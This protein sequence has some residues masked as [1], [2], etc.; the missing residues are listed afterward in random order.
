MHDFNIDQFKYRIRL[1]V[2]L[3][4]VALFCFSAWSIISDRKAALVT[5]EHNVTGYARALAEHSES[6]FAESDRVLRDLLYD[7]KRES[8]ER[9]LGTQELFLELRRQ[10][11]D[12]PQIGA[13][14]LVDKNGTMYSN[15]NEFPP[16]PISVVDREYFQFYLHH[17]EAELT[18]SKPVMSRLVNRWRFN[19]MRPMSR[20]GEPFSGIAA[21]AFEVGYF[22]SFFTS[23]SLGPSGRI[24]LVRNDGAPLVCEP[25][26]KN[27]FDV[28]M[29]N[30]V[31]FRDKL[32][33]APS[34]SYRVDRGALDG[35]ARI[36]AYQRLKR[37]PVV[38]LVSVSEAE[39][40][41][42]WERRALQQLLLTVAISFILGYLTRLILRHL[43]RLKFTIALVEGQQEQLKV[44]AALMEAANDAIV[45]TETTGKLIQFNPALCQMTGFSNEELS[46]M[47]LQD[48]VT[49]ESA[50][51]FAFA[52]DLLKERDSISYESAFQTK[53]GGSVPV[54]VHSLNMT[55]DSRPLVLNIARDITQRKQSERREQDRLKILEELATG[56][57]L[58]D[59]LNAIVRFV[60]QQSP[61]ALCSV[62]LFD[63]DKGRLR[64]GAA[65]SLPDF[66][67]KAVD[68]ILI[69]MGVG[70]CGTAAFLKKRVVVEDVVGHPHW[71][72]FQP[73]LDAGLRACWSEPILASDGKLIGTFAIYNREPKAPGPEEIALIESAAH[74]ASL[75]IERSRGDENRKRL[76]E[77][78][79]HVQK[80]DAIGQLAAGVAHD[81]NNLLTPILVYA[82]LLRTTVTDEKQ[83]KKADG[84]ASAALKAKEL[85]QKLLSFGRKQMLH[86]EVLDLN[87][88]VRSFEEIITRTVRESIVVDLELSPEPLEVN[89]DRGQLEQ[90]LLNLVVNAQDAIRG[91]GTVTVRSERKELEKGFVRPRPGLKVGTYCHLSFSD[92]GCGMDE[93]TLQHIFEPFFTTKPVGEGTG[94][95]LATIYGIVKQH[96]G[97]IEVQSRVGEGSTFDIY[98]PAAAG[99][100]KP[101]PEPAP[102]RRREGAQGTVLV[103][104]DNEMIR[105]M[106]VELLASAGYQVLVAEQPLQA[107]ELVHETQERID[108]LVTDVV[109]PQMNGPELY[110][111]LVQIRPELPVLYMSGYAED[112][113]AGDQM[114][115]SSGDL[116]RKPFTSDTFLDYVGRKLG[117]LPG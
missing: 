56:G 14:F 92:N 25:M 85:T 27:V 23:A 67:N 65:P 57:G 102:V 36:V 105:E 95:G 44:K 45:Q 48:I 97:Y 16:R 115:W 12:S 104:E 81:F 110:A 8:K 20:P 62:L 22:Q 13:L 86:K 28:D 72:G 18:I 34:G 9:A 6:A 94:L 75:A 77:Q 108:L 64:H 88:V 60:E 55:S 54:E 32:P 91:N 15:S 112:V 2:E 1:F 37:F 70:S 109:M 73:V 39:V 35:K 113:A 31:L 79:L 114:K 78:L 47:K 46:R 5:A 90:I 58:P 50:R 19:L 74:L 82:G 10:A 89:A 66:Y 7:M 30:S 87:E 42:P 106:A 83:M 52:M 63:E 41:A 111:T 59:L 51:E 71:K 43:D 80:I 100:A 40:L 11:A 17:P 38:S 84:I 29:G 117:A 101:A 103:V 98:L 116:L 21:V 107:I 68:G 76:E 26:I 4:I 69:G 3:I 53:E 99:A 93:N 24:A 33:V 49:E 61:G 96:E